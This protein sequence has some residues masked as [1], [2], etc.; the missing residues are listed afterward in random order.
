M[1][2]DLI[3]TLNFDNEIFDQRLQVV[4]KGFSSIESVMEGFALGLT[5]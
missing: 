3:S 2:K 5:K 4:T 1:E